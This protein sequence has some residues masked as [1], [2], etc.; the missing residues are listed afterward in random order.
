M[1]IL[2]VIQCSNLGG[3]EK[4]TLE[5][6]S[7]LRSSGHEVRMLSLHPVG[8]LKSLAGERGICLSGTKKYM[9]GGFGNMGEIRRIIKEYAP[10]RIWLVGHNLGSLVAAKLSG[11]PTFLSIHYHHSERPVNFWRCFYAV[12][13]W[14]CSRI[15]FVS[16]YIYGEVSGF[17]TAAD[18][19]VCFPNMIQA[20]ETVLSK[21][22]AREMLGLPS[23][24]FV[25]GNAGWLIPRKAF[26]IFLQTAALVRAHIP[27]AVFIIAGDGF[28]RERLEDMQDSLGLGDAVQF[29][30][31]KTDLEPVYG[32][33]DVLLFNAHFDCLPTTPLEAMVRGIPVVCSLPNGGLKEIIRHGQDGFL[34]DTHDCEAMAN[35]VI[36]LHNDPEAVSVTVA[37]GLARVRETCS[38]KCHLENLIRF[39]ELE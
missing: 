33:L 25:V 39:L 27:G 35:E 16:R 36:R 9:W 13:K 20:P 2:N 14:C 30:G 1:K 19:V 22:A 15:H 37:S 24:A 17:F 26:D 31:W 32:A 11:Y 21:K 10:D 28:E 8:D 7:L 34:I 6:L 4:V 5:S 12:A 29:L 18:H 38:P 23:N 3:M